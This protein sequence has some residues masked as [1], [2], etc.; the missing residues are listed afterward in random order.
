MA[1]EFQWTIDIIIQLGT[2][3]GIL[4]VGIIWLYQRGKHAGKQETCVQD[5]EKNLKHINEKIDKIKETIG[6]KTESS[7]EEHNTL[8]KRIT[9]VEKDVA[10]IKGKIDQALEKH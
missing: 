9:K 3:I 4:A 2:L 10:Y 7:D 1:E 8:H 6:E 5:I